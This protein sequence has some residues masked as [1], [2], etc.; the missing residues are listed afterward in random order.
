MTKPEK[1]IHFDS[2]INMRGE[3][4]FLIQAMAQKQETGSLSEQIPLPMEYAV[5]N[6]STEERRIMYDY[7]VEVG[8]N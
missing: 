1:L 2:A 5:Y 4:Y 8:L 7:I 6:L 3:M